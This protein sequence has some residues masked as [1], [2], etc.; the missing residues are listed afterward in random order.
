M[1]LN[2][3]ALLY[4]LYDKKFTIEI[5]GK[6]W[7]NNY[8]EGDLFELWNYLRQKDVKY[9]VIWLQSGYN[10]QLSNNK[11]D[12]RVS[13]ENCKIFFICKGDANDSYQKRFDTTYTN[14]L[15]PLLNKFLAYKQGVTLSD[16]YRF[17]TLPFNA[18]DGAGQLMNDS[19][20]R[21]QKATIQDIWDAIYLEIDIHLD[22]E[23]F[24]EFIIK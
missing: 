3:N 15:Y 8:T 4:S 2:H 9:P 22:K 16:D 6:S 13:L 5:N 10:V 19:S 12:S 18:I 17:K 23:C 7:I 14:M 21:G 20:L 11:G 1:I 24:Q